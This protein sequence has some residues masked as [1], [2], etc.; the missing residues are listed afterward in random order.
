M[1]SKI[2]VK[3]SA[4]KSLDKSI[5]ISSCDLSG[6][7]INDEYGIKVEIVGTPSLIEVNGIAGV[8]VFAKAW[9]NNQQIGFGDDGSI[10]IERFQ[11]F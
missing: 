5:E 9:K 8:E 10:E 6:I 7:Y 1:N 11:V 4:T 2:D 3:N